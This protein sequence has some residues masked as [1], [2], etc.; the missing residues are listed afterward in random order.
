MGVAEKL[1]CF[2]PGTPGRGGEEVQKLTNSQSLQ[3]VQRRAW[4]W[5]S[6]IKLGIRGRIFDPAPV[7]PAKAFLFSSSSLGGWLY[8]PLGGTCWDTVQQL[9]FHPTKHEEQRV[10]FRVR[11]GQFEDDCGGGGGD[12]ESGPGRSPSPGNEK[13][14]YLLL[15]EVEVTWLTTSLENRLLSSSGPYNSLH[16]MWVCVC[17]LW[18]WGSH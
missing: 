6:C 18:G 11:L 2:H 4:C 8:E 3:Y 1:K 5:L 13:A 9:F 15:S 16:L 12:M 7:T 14:D 10:G 17:E